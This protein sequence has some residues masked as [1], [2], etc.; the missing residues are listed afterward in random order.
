MTIESDRPPP[1]DKRATIGRIL[2]AAY[3]VFG[4][5][6]LELATMDGVAERARLSK[7]L[8]Y[9]YFGN[10]E[11]LYVEVLNEHL[12]KSHLPV[13]AF[14]FTALEPL[15]A[16]R[17]LFELA[18]DQN[19]HHAGTFAIDQLSTNSKFD[20]SD[21]LFERYGERVTALVEGILA[22]GRT[23]GSMRPDADPQLVHALIWVLNVGFLSSRHLL[24]RY[25]AADLGSPAAAAAWR[26]LSVE[27]ILAAVAADRPADSDRH[28]L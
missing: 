24:S 19:L 12:R 6:G 1:Q 7:Q 15:Q 21:S 11:R 27:A 20:L 10:K 23:D 25:M 14:D 17:K 5:R 26:M 13:L 9:H 18:Y 28:A 4:E 22:R 2:D 16:L 8:I 3:E